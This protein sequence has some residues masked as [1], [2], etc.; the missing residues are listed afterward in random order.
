MLTDRQTEEK[1]KEKDDR[2]MLTD[3]QTE[4]KI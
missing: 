1:Y 3:R 2:Q 4:R